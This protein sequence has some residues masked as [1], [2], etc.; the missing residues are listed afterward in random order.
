MR[1]PHEDIP[2]LVVSFLDE[3]LQ[4][5][6]EGSVPGFVSLHDFP[7]LLVDNEKVVVFVDYAG[8]YVGIIH[9]GAKIMTICQFLPGGTA[10]VIKESVA[11]G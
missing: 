2:W 3:C 1:H 10:L 4:D 7:D 6:G 11:S 9:C 5:L 8:C